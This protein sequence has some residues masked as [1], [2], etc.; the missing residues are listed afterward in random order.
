MSGSAGTWIFAVAAAAIVLVF[1][2]SLYW[3]SGRGG[4]R[5]Q[6]LGLALLMPILVVAGYV[7]LGNPAA[8]EPQ[9]AHPPMP[10]QAEIN[11]MVERL[12]ARLKE[13]PD[14][15]KGWVMLA[16]SYMTMGRYA[17]ADAAYEHA[18][19]SVMEDG[20][21]LVNWIHLRLALNGQKLDDRTR[22]LVD[23][24]WKLAPDDSDVMLMR[25]YADFSRG[26]KAGADALVAKL[27]E[28]YA[29]GTG[30][31]QSLE[32]ALDILMPGG[33]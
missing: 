21:L 11:A 9:R 6:T 10:G 15:P 5:I 18:R 12:A 27:R 7:A 3:A 32:D 25:A 1:G 23:Q 33:K 19:A 14:D 24:A 26:D 13:N 20:E 29:L 17:D 8:L 28:R 31:R 30:E 22:E 2:A 4:S 16:R